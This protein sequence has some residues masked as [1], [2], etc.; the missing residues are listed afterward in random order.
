V[1][2][3]IE[4]HQNPIEVLEKFFALKCF[5]VSDKNYFQTFIIRRIADEVK[6]VRTSTFLGLLAWIP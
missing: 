1:I 2:Q 4:L 5:K 6:P 3:S